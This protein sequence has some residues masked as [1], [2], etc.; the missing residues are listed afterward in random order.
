MTKTAIEILSLVVSL[1]ALLGTVVVVDWPLIREWWADRKFRRAVA[2]W[3][4][5]PEAQAAD[6]REFEAK[7]EV[8]TLEKWLALVVPQ[9]A[10]HPILDP[11]DY[12]LTKQF[13]ADLAE[14]HNAEWQHVP[15]ELK[16]T[17]YT[18]DEMAHD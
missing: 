9:E 7:Q 14:P 2:A 4:R 12:D 8:L 11:L 1:A 17:C 3:E 10:A 15:D 16:T 6:Q 13:T 5:S 18:G